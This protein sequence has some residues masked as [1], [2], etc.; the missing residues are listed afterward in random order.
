MMHV[1]HVNG[2]SETLIEAR[3]VSLDTVTD[4][5]DRHNH[6]KRVVVEEPNG[7]KH[8]FEY[9]DV[10]VMSDQGKTIQSYWLGEFV[11]WMNRRRPLV[12]EALGETA[13]DLDEVGLGYL[14]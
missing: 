14:K 7:N 11:A 13:A 2:L 9:G 1:K 12:S 8:I 10:Y 4:A 5:P 6:V 3:Q